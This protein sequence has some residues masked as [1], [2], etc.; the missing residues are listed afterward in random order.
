[1]IGKKLIKVLTISLLSGI[2]LFV[3]SSVRADTV[4]ER[5]ESKG[6]LRI[7][8][9]PNEIPLSYR[10]NNGEL[11]GICLDLVN[12]IK[13]ELKQSLNRNIIT[14]HIFSSN[15]SNRF[16]IVQDGIVDLECGAN[17]IRE[18]ENYQVSFSQPFFVTGT[19]FLV[20]RDKARQL[21]DDTAIE[22]IRI[23]VL[24]DTTTEEY[25][26]QRFPQAQISLYRGA[27]GSA[28]GVRAVEND[29]IDAFADDGILLLGAATSLSMSLTRDFIL[30]PET[31]VTCERYGL[32]LPENDPDWKEL[33][34]RVINSSEE[35]EIV[36]D[37][38]GVAD[39][40]INNRPNCSIDD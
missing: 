20:A 36:G 35:R 32:I 7:G 30:L 26:R 17:T 39:R 1:M 25:V 38:F 40:F 14:T 33:I 37:W 31:P 27:N 16:Q 3:N 12:L 29:R 10:D 6:L 4:L 13:K 21:I 15:L 8:I 28:L 9:N 11:Q 24:G 23:G 18:V 34:D 19:Q 5:I 2:N 22:D